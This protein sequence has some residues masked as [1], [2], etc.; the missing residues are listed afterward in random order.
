MSKTAFLLNARDAAQALS[1]SRATFFN[2]VR[3]GVIEKPAKIGKRSAWPVSAI[4]DAAR[5]IVQ[6]ATKR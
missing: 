3:E 6:G 4:E 5:R 2:L 1:V